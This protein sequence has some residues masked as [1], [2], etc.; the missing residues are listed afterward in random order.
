[1]SPRL[2]AWISLPA[3][4]LTFGRSRRTLR[5]W[6]ADPNLRIRTEERDGERVI[7]TA[8]LTRVEAFKHAYTVAPTFGRD[9]PESNAGGV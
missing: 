9:H 3:A 1:M 2:P 7:N 8:D 5:R 4:A 6:L